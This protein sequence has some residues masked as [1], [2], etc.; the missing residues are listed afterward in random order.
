MLPL[1]EGTSWL[2]ALTALVAASSIAVPGCGGDDDSGHGG[3]AG[4]SGHAGASA[5]AGS[6]GHEDEHGGQSGED[7]ESGHA[8]AAGDTAGASELGGSSS[9]PGGG[10]GHGGGSNGGMAGNTGIAGDGGTGTGG[11]GGTAGAGAGGASA[12]TGNTVR[13]SC[14]LD[15][16][17]CD[18]LVPCIDGPTGPACG[19][20]PGGFDG[21]GRS[22]CAPH[23]CSGAPD[24]SC[25]CVRVAVDGNDTL[26][27]LT[28]GLSPFQTVQAAVDYADQHR[29][30]ARAVCVAGGT[31][32]GP[33][34]ADL[35][36]RDGISV[37][38]GYE[39]TG[40]TRTSV[41]T[42]LAP[43]TA[44]GVVFGPD[45][46]SA[47]ELSGFTVNLPPTDTSTGV[48]IDGAQDVLVS[49]IL[50]LNT[51]PVNYYGVDVSNGADAALSGITLA[52]PL[53]SDL[54]NTPGDAIGIRVSDSHVTI[55]G[56]GITVVAG[57]TVRAL[58]LMNA[59]G[60]ITGGTFRVGS[61]P[62]AQEL[63]ALRVRNGGELALTSSRF[64]MMGMF[65]GGALSTAAIDI[66]DSVEVTARQTQVKS[67]GGMGLG[68]SATRSKL[69]FD[70]HVE[71]HGGATYPWGAGVRL[72]D[73][74]GSKVSGT[75]DAT[76]AYGVAVTGNATGVE[77]GGAIETQD[78]GASVNFENCGDTS[79][80]LSGASVK[81]TVTGSAGDG[82][83]SVDC[84][85]RISG[86][87][88]TVTTG[89]L[90][91]DKHLRGIHCMR[92]SSTTGRCSVTDNTVVVSSPPQRTGHPPGFYGT[93][94][95]AALEGDCESVTGNRLSALLAKDD[96]SYFCDTDLW[97][98]TRYGG[99]GAIVR[100]AEL[101]SGN[102][103][104]AGC[105]GA[106]AGL[107]AS[108]RI[109][110]NV[111]IGPMCGSFGDPA[112]TLHCDGLVLNGD[113]VVHSNTI[114][115]GAAVA[116]PPTSPFHSYYGPPPPCRSVGLVLGGQA[117]VRNN[118][119]GAGG[120]QTVSSVD[121]VPSVAENNDFVGGPVDFGGAT[122]SGNFS[123]P[124]FLDAN[125]R[126]QAGSPC[127]DAGT[128]VDA[129]LTDRDGDVRDAHPDVGA[130]E[131]SVCAVANGGCDPLATCRAL[132][133]GVVCGACPSGYT[134][135]G[136]NGC[137]DIDECESN[138]H[139]C[140]SAGANYPRYVD[141]I[142]TNTPGSWSCSCPTGYEYVETTNPSGAPVKECMDRDECLVGWGGCGTAD[143]INT[144]G[145]YHCS[146]CQTGYTNTD[147]GCVDDDECTTGN[148]GCDPLTLCTNM[149]GGYACGDC[150]TG[151]NGSGYTGCAPDPCAGVTCQNGGTCVT[152]GSAPACQCP[153]GVNGERCQIVF[154]KL[155]A[156][157]LGMC[158]LRSD[159][160]LVCW[161][162][163]TFASV[164][165]G[166]FADFDA[167]LAEVCTLDAAGSI[168][169]FGE[170]DAAIGNPP[171][172]AFTSVS[173]GGGACA[174]AED[175][176]LH[177]WGVSG[178][179][180]S[181]TFT[182]VAF[183]ENH[184]CAIRTDESVACWMTVPDLDRGQASPPSGTFLAIA[185]GAQATCGLRT[186]GTL[187]CWG[188]DY[189]DRPVVAPPGQFIAFDYG[190]AYGCG[191]K[192]DRTLQCWGTPPFGLATTPA[193]GTF[194]SISV[195]GYLPCG[196]RTDHSVAC[197]GPFV[198]STPI[199][200]GQP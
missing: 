106:G 195:D 189:A 153:D 174:I 116:N 28:G 71:V 66:E 135:D 165:P 48:T 107:E 186:D 163:T 111:I 25:A 9:S 30:H 133:S 199:P 139:D 127:I 173:V 19:A 115:G 18:T 62:S 65:A 183:G 16:G 193:A 157:L 20:C 13:P 121:G 49:V 162:D 142:C 101:V 47:T 117:V 27:E 176:S 124:A 46:Q 76:S 138:T 52:P 129:P 86:N 144:P 150:P 184:V 99:S 105:S 113:A 80:L 148:G 68:V 1:R 84:R 42:I 172:S 158:G 108:G 125:Y 96:S 8:G 169:C 100:G 155:S 64:E 128:P 159:G 187:A 197:W 178:T 134:G 110:N 7:G 70:G 6:A 4:D 93:I 29:N 77:L 171:S 40:W 50:T 34:N 57:G 58:S 190:Q 14:A 98:L 26:G 167:G 36:M 22:G 79:P 72:V 145:G 126:L 122:A 185:A 83:R 94:W 151:Y 41:P 103:I 23:P 152:D 118:I 109:E 73:A 141:G 78:S 44:R 102:V 194:Q 32:A 164:P 89:E 61:T 114:F 24:L 196:L 175:R 63:T 33:S 81:A 182:S 132:A 53:Q 59:S 12:G 37:Y 149:P 54:W 161:N 60:S 120:C 112:S 92:S 156:T 137:T 15:N 5:S 147:H 88:V 180:P 67:S 160:T 146:G 198:D 119:V 177:C 11:R 181:G 170:G 123:A 97:G 90:T 192:P 56:G 130:D 136:E 45:V 17:G 55:G 154:E 179:P 104:T 38:G 2:R 143:C 31:Y 188:V 51:T 191:I 21:D 87:Q 166:P 85:A 74:P 131:R 168:G 10:S 39:S 200:T 95:S 91:N 75:I 35:A 140:P 82:I 69:S 3:T 43:A